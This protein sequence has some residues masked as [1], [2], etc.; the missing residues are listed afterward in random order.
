M[1]LFFSVLVGHTRFNLCLLYRYGMH[2]MVR[3]CSVVLTQHLPVIH[4][5][6]FVPLIIEE[7]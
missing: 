5:P 6:D 4:R 3:R 2:L 7:C 1:Q